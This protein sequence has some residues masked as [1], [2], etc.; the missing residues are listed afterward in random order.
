MTRQEHLFLKLMEECAEVQHRVSKLLQFGSDE[1]QEGQSSNNSQRLRAE[2]DDL[3]S[4]TRLLEEDGL[5][6]KRSVVESDKHLEY[7]RERIN[8]YL[9]ISQSRGKVD[10][11]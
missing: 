2:L 11:E 8:K 1:I 5:I 10:I 9:K 4:T 7:K 6:I 3:F